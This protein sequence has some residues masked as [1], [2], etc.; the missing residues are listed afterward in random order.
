M[1][2]GFELEVRVPPKLAR[3]G[4]REAPLVDAAFR[5]FAN[6]AEGSAQLNASGRVLRRRSGKLARNIRATVRRAGNTV[7]VT[8]G[9]YT[10]YARIQEKGG[11]TRPHLIRPRNASVL[12][13]EKDGRTIF[14]TLVH[15]PGSVIPARPYLEPA[16][17]EH[18]PALLHELVE[19]YAGAA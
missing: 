11:R 19:I 6:R 1:A 8:L 4:R 9:A 13:F 10:I 12:V 2:E 7:I 14:A 5:R 16:L 18:L 3:L 17:R 15:H